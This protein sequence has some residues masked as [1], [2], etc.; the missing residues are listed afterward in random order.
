VKVYA[1]PA[2]EAGCGHYRLIWPAQVLQSRGYN[3]VIVGK[4]DRGQAL[5]GKMRGNQMVDVAIP[6][7]ADVIV[8]QRVTHRYLVQAIKLIRQRGVAVV[9]DMD[10][11]LTCI[12]PSNPAFHM[13]HPRVGAHA[14]HSWENT[15]HA[16]DA[17]TVVT[18]STPALVDRYARRRPGYVLYNMVPK[19]Y[20]DV[21]RSDSDV[22]GWGGAVFSHPADLQVMGPAVAQLLQVGG[23]FKVV[24]PIDGA[25]SALGV[26]SSKEIETT[27][28][29]ANIE[30]WPLG[31]ASLGV[32][33]APLADTKFNSAKSWLKM[34]EYAAVGVPV[35][36][37]PRAEYARLHKLGVGW[38]AKSPSEWRTKILKLARDANLRAEL[39]EAGREVMKHRTIEENAWR[40]WEAWLEALELERSTLKRE[41]AAL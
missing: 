40:W 38:L 18:T 15:L 22:V 2:D 34:A 10:D 23:R 13:L 29:I 17:A 27:G 32:G 39:S 7:D 41:V 5:Q 26:S 28:N 30:A 21:P 24:G 31:I 20:L 1:F 14:D 4:N 8:L 36:A 35:I 11:D 33:V 25:H 37:S 6:E 16:C 9:I 12:H 19:R 3:V